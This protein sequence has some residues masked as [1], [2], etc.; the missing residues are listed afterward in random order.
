MKKLFLNTDSDRKPKLIRLINK[1]ISSPVGVMLLAVMSALAF[2]FSREF[3]FY[4]FV[5]VYAIYVALFADDFS[6][7]MPL[8]IF[9]YIT[10]SAINNPGSS[11]ESVFWGE[12]GAFLVSFVLV[13]IA[14]LLLRIIFDKKIGIKRFLF[15]K[16]E[17][18]FGLLILGAAFLVSGYGSEHYAEL[19]EKN[20]FFAALQFLA[21]F[22]SMNKTP[23]Q[24]LLHTPIIIRTGN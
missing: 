23:G 21:F 13:P 22:H 3:E 24:Y 15:E 18:L 9:C 20:L 11:E 2:A 8:F 19:K 16:R 4:S 6:P 12:R 7:L 1:I 14:L 5:I 17:L 10:P